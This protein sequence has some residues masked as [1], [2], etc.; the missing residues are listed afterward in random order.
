MNFNSRK[1]YLDNAIKPEF[2]V[3]VIQPNSLLAFWFAVTDTLL[4]EPLLQSLL[5][6][7]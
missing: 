7:C 3:W 6:L 2:L 1:L 4:V 5:D